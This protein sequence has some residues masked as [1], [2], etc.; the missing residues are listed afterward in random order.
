[1]DP[2]RPSRFIAFIDESGDHSTL[3]IDRDFPV[4]VLSM[5]IVSRSDYVETIIPKLGRLKLALWPHEGV[6]L[7]SRDIRRGSGDFAV[8]Q[9]P[10][11]REAMYAAIN[12]LMSCEYTL[13]IA[14][15][16]KDR[17][18]EEARSTYEP[19]AMALESLLSGADDFLQAQGE[20]ALPFIAESRG[21]REDA[22]IAATFGRLEGKA[23][24][25]LIFGRK[26][27][28]IAGLQIADLAAYP[29]AR[30]LLGGGRSDPSLEILLPRLYRRGNRTGLTILP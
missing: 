1:M 23:G 2:G 24:K 12:D 26:G 3:P 30:H 22:E 27:D 29:F 18:R 19:Y 28:N 25:S 5:V 14:A 16:R 7:H 21:K 9:V 20:S 11:I 4:F 17:M 15:I 6:N 13:F 10:S 8:L